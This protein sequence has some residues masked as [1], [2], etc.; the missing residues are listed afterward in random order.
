MRNS[1]LGWINAFYNNN[2]YR[3]GDLFGEAKSADSDATMCGL[4]YWD[5][6]HADDSL[7]DRRGMEIVHGAHHSAMCCHI[8]RFQVT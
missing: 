3:Y 7:G 2:I 1:D 8:L 4:D 6:H 5:V